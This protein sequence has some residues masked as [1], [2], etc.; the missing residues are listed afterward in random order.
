MKLVGFGNIFAGRGARGGP[1]VATTVRRRPD[2]ILKSEPGKGSFKNCVKVLSVFCCSGLDSSAV[3]Y[4]QRFI[5]LFGKL[6]CRK[7][8]S[9]KAPKAAKPHRGLDDA[10][11]AL[12]RT[13]FSRAVQFCVFFFFFFRRPRKCVCTTFDD[14]TT[15]AGKRSVL[16]QAGC[17]EGPWGSCGAVSGKRAY[18]RT[19]QGPVLTTTGRLSSKDGDKNGVGRAPVFPSPF[20]IWFVRLYNRS[21]ALSTVSFLSVFE[22]FLPSERREGF[23]RKKD[24]MDGKT[25]RIDVAFPLR[26]EA[27]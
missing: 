16:R 25:M 2:L 8:V 21:C 4:Y 5:V 11:S 18:Q 19:S 23:P 27:N 13:I 9:D 3:F 12:K 10:T 17:R 24:K 7:C 6:Q 14:A 1:I 20:S 22:F 26:A 15:T